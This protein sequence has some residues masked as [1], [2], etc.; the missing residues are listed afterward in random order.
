MV[1]QLLSSFARRMRW[2]PR[3]GWKVL[4]GKEQP[5]FYKGKGSM[6]TGVHTRKKGFHLVESVLPQYVVPDLTGFPLKPYVSLVTGAEVPVS[7]GRAVL[8]SKERDHNA[9]KP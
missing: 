7:G 2:V 6:K 8:E 5:K 9:S 3:T 1:T 4:S